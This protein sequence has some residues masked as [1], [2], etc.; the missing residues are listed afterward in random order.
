MYLFYA[1]FAHYEFGI[2]ILHGIKN[3]KLAAGIS[4]NC[5]WSAT[6]RTQ[7]A[8]TKFG[9]RWS[10]GLKTEGQAENGGKVSGP[11]L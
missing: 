8:R 11:F 2:F 6:Q 7:G 9:K 1:I 4:G 5:G 10:A 3:E